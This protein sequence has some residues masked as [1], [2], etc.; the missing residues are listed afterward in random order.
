MAEKDS[1]TIT[2]EIMERL[3]EDC[4]ANC[5]SIEKAQT[6]MD[7]MAAISYQALLA[8]DGG[9]HGRMVGEYLR[10]LGSPWDPENMQESTF[11]IILKL[12]GEAWTLLNKC[13]D[14]TYLFKEPPTPEH[15][16]AVEKGRQLAEA[17]V[18]DV[19]EVTGVE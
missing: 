12:A 11:Q 10:K 18:K 13:S 8:G 16:V 5:A 3:K 14:P 15:L 1:T 6:L 9:Q 4:A 7:A 17:F 2:P 19:Q